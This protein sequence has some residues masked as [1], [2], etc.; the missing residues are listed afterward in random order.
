MLLTMFFV[1]L[2]IACSGIKNTYDYDSSIDFTQLKAYQ[3]DMQPSA[4]FSKANQLKAKRIVRAIEGNMKRKGI[5]KTDSADI[6]ISYSVNYEKKLKSGGLSAGVGMSVGRSNRGS[7]SLSS[8]NQL[9]QTTI[10]SLMIDMVSTKNN[11]LIW[12]SITTKPVTDRPATPEESQKRISQ[13]VYG[14]FENFPPK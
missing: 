12:R 11:R 2:L 5:V 10:G 3:W 6:K 7:I 4:E 1:S 8:G 13:L 14:V 9:R